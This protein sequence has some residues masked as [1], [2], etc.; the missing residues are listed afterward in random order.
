[1]FIDKHKYPLVQ[2]I[3]GNTI[4]NTYTHTNIVGEQVLNYMNQTSSARVLQIYT[5][6]NFLVIIEHLKKK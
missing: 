6:V 3:K 4:N 5:H 2:H 1:M